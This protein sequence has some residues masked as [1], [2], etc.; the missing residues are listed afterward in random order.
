LFPNDKNNKNNKNNKNQQG[1]INKYVNI[2]VDLSNQ[3]F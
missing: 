1:E 3:I 2:L